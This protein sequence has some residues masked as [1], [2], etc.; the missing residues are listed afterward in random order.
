VANTADDFVSRYDVID[1][2]YS[3][4]KNAPFDLPHLQ[5]PESLQDVAALQIE[6]GILPAG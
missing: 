2:V 1:T 5:R 6:S 3:S 4:A